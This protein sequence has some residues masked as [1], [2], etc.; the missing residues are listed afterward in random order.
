MCLEIYELDPARFYTAPELVWKAALRKTLLKLDLLA[1]T[2]ILLMIVKVIEKCNN[3][4]MKSHD[5][6]KESSY[7]KY[8]E[9]NIVYGLAM[10]QTFT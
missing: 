4:Y 10:S 6:N 8:W 7:L 9:V 2:D 3:N 1:D 5:K